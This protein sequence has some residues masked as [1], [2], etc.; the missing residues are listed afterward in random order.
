[1]DGAQIRVMKE[2]DE[3]GFSGLLEGEDGLTLPSGRT[4][5]GGH[6]LRNLADL[7]TLVF[8]RRAGG[9]QRTSRWKGVLSSRRSVVF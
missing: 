1:V 9:A 8:A 5:L 7:Q 2:I 6:L 4:L 3:E